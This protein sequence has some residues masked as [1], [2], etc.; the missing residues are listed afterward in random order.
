MIDAHAI[1]VDAYA[2]ELD[3]GNTRTKW[4]WLDAADRT[5]DSGAWV[6]DSSPL[7]NWLPQAS[8]TVFRARVVSVA[9]SA[10]E[11]SNMT[12]STDVAIMM[13]G[14]EDGKKAPG[15][16]QGVTYWGLG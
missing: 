8:E 6:R 9:G 16:G 2:L 15:A 10:H 14:T 3:A 5:L 12:R 4:R 7:P 1:P 11:L 13:Q